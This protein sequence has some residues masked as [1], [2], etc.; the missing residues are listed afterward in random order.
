MRPGVHRRFTAGVH[1]HEASGAV[2]VAEL[3]R[4]AA[5]PRCVAV[6]AKPPDADICLNKGA[7]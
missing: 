1:P 5:D 3:R 6:G 2:D 4:L 7:F